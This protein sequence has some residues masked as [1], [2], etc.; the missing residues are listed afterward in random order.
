[1]ITDSHEV[2]QTGRHRQT[3]RDCLRVGGDKLE[4]KWPRTE[5]RQWHTTWQ[6]QNIILFERDLIS[7]EGDIHTLAMEN[8]YGTGKEM[9]KGGLIGDKEM[10]AEDDIRDFCPMNWLQR[11]EQNE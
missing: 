2:A 10:G 3:L 11:L 5:W 9:G 8:D 6:Q 4:E 7:Y 1:M